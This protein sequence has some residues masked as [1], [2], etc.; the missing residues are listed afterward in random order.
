[1][2][3][4]GSLQQL[5]RAAFS[6]SGMASTSAGGS[7]AA[8]GA[9]LQSLAGEL[10]GAAMRA[11]SPLAWRA[12][13]TASPAAA[14]ADAGA[15]APALNPLQQAPPPAF[16]DA[17]DADLGGA[18]TDTS[19]SRATARGLSISPRKL[20]MF[21][22][23]I[24]GLAVQDAV[25]QCDMSPKKSAEICKKVLLS[26]RANALNNHG[27]D[28]AR[29]RV[30]QSVPAAAG[31]LASWESHSP[32]LYEG[33][34]VLWVCTHEAGAAP[35]YQ[36]SQSR[37]VQP[38]TPP[39]PP[40][41]P[42]PIPALCRRG[43]CG[44]GHA[45]EAADDARQGAVGVAAAVPLTPDGGAA[46]GGGRGAAPHPHPP[47]APRAEEGVGHA[48]RPGA[49]ARRAA[50]AFGVRHRRGASP[51][52]GHSLCCCACCGLVFWFNSLH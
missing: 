49:G 30:G 6:L 29:L 50:A 27:L 36:G 42:L 31:W 32:T 7:S 4:R 44:A 2:A 16:G 14:A 28:D 52:V 3:L 26:A 37:C 45:P 22:K 13:H 24:R 34:P 11:T 25:I 8:A 19:L 17:G 20:N 21:A 35:S 5:R 39:P 46:G 15:A 38:L 41:L 48:R 9:A 43:V 12:L 1:M 23:L 47:H 51:A 10:Q 40:R 33:W 18:A